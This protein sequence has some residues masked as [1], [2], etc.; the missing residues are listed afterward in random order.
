MNFPDETVARLWNRIKPNITI[1]PVT[2]C[3]HF[4]PEAGDGKYL[5]IKIPHRYRINR[6][7]EF[8]YVTHIAWQK[9]VGVIPTNARLWR[10]CSTK[11]CVRPSHLEVKYP[12]YRKQ[13]RKLD[14]LAPT[15]AL[16]IQIDM[17]TGCWLYLPTGSVHE[18]LHGALTPKK[19]SWILY[20][21]GPD[22]TAAIK[23]LQ[24][25]VVWTTCGT[26]VCA[27]PYHL[28][29]RPRTIPDSQDRR[30]WID[31]DYVD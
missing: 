31:E 14:R 6:G 18:A 16:D 23:K 15:F 5:R 20:R 21:E 13:L 27:N 11:D 25:F 22:W 3:W 8:A 24:N 7:Q 19:I 29:I 12:N 28:V 2:G 10:V 9:F 4:P 1:D 30:W 26:P 17:Q